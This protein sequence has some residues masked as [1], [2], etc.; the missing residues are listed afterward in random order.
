MGEYEVVSSGKVAIIYDELGTLFDE[1]VFID[2]SG[3]YI[4]KGSAPQNRDELHAFV[5]WASEQMGV[6]HLVGKLYLPLEA[7]NWI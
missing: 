2:E 6:N 4:A 1:A 5:D 3:S 7:R